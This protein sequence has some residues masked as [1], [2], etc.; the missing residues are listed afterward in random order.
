MTVKLSEFFRV[1]GGYFAV[2]YDGDGFEVLGAH[3]CAEAARARGVVIGKDYSHGRHILPSRTY[4][5]YTSLA[6]HL[7]LQDVAGC[8]C[9]FT[10]R[11]DASLIFW[12]AVLGLKGKPAVL[13]CLGQ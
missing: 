1:G 7:C 2:A 5:Q 10:H 8:D 6:A 4:R 9:A 11:A 3:D 12:F 13:P